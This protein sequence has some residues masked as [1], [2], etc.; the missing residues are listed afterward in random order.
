MEAFISQTFLTLKAII[1]VLMVSTIEGQLTQGTVAIHFHETK[2][3]LFLP[4]I[5]ANL[6]LDLPKTLS[7]IRNTEGLLIIIIVI[8]GALSKYLQQ[9]WVG[10]RQEFSTWGGE[11]GDLSSHQEL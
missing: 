5:I 2:P 8:P 4:M 1:L 10:G 6:F 3:L 7:L 9:L 11:L